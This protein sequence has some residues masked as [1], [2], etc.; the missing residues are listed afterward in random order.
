MTKEDLN[1]SNKLNNSK[2][3][4]EILDLKILMFIQIETKTTRL[5]KTSTLKIQKN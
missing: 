5:S 3:N 1:L 4:S 2:E